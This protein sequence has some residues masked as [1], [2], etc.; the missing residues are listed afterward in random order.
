MTSEEAHERARAAIAGAKEEGTTFLNFG[1]GIG[2]DSEVHDFLPAL[3]SLPAELA[4]LTTLTRLDLDHT[5]I[6]DAGL[7]ALNHL[8]GLQTLVLNETPVTDEGLS[9]LTGLTDLQTLFL[10]GTRITKAGLR[11]L[12]AVDEFLC[13][14]GILG[15]FGDTRHSGY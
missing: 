12:A 5:E 2:E 9:A 15:D 8:T 10:S 7:S 4:E 14:G 6:T 1:V 3:T 11:Q 13:P